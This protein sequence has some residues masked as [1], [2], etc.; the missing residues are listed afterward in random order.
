MDLQAVKTFFKIRN[1][2]LTDK[3]FGLLFSKVSIYK[4]I[5]R[6]EFL[7]EKGEIDTNMYFI[8]KGAFRSYIVQNGQEYR[9]VLRCTNDLY[10][11]YI[12]FI[13]QTPSRYYL[14]ALSNAEILGITRADYYQLVEDNWKIERMWRKETEQL[15][16]YRIARDHVLRLKAKDRIKH[17]LQV[18]PA[19][20]KEIPNKYLASYLRMSPETFSREFRLLKEEK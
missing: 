6:F 17:F 20:F 12:S 9:D 3:D 11:N 4:K 16:I 19:L 18:K 13:N 7:V 15:F 1:P 5:K 2:Q 8:L 14:Q 10:C